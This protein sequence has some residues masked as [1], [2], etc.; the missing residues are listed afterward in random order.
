MPWVS[1]IVIMFG[2]SIMV[3]FVFNRL[4]KILFDSYVKVPES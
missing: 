4:R 3:L 2:L 1:D